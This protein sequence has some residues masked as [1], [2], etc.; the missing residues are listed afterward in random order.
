MAFGTIVTLTILPVL[1]FALWHLTSTMLPPIPALLRNKRIILLI[2]HPD[3]ESMFFS[4]A[5]QALT[6]PSLQNHLKILCMS[7][8]NSEGLGATRKQ[9]LEKAATTLGLRRKED[10]FVLEDERFK[11]GMKEEWKSEDIALVLASAFAPHLNSPSAAAAPAMPTSDSDKEK[12]KDRRKSKPNSVKHTKSASRTSIATPPAPAQ[13]EVEGPRATI[14]VL[15]TFDKDGISGHP[16]HI[17]LY[18]GASLFLQKIMK[19][20]SGYACPVTLYTLPS[21][22][23]VRKYSFVLDAI[24]TLLAGIYETIFGNLFGSTTGKGKTATGPKSAADRVMFVNDIFRYWKAREAM[25]HGHKS[26]M[27]WF[28]WGWIGLGRYMVVNDLR[29]ERVVAG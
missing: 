4:P 2:A 21:I 16:N 20:H 9:E 15:I 26:Q 29:R 24:P 22:N 12:D 1:I 8:G 5:L 28:R 11:D 14:D 10:V 18:H 19:G 27:V 3:D 13:K 17:A 23:I 6:H 25:I 7:T